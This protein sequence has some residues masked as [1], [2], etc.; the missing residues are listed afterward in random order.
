MPARSEFRQ[1]IFQRWS[2]TWQYWTVE[3]DLENNI[4]RQPGEEGLEE[5]MT[6]SKGSGVLGRRILA[7]VKRFQRRSLGRGGWV[8]VVMRKPWE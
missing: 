2:P 8:V 4:A 3:P 5:R 1:L 7:S 6:R